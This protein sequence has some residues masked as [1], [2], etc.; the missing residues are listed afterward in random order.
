MK[1]NRQILIL[2]FLLTCFTNLLA[3][4]YL[5]DAQNIT[6]QHG[7]S[8][9]MTSAVFH[10]QQGFLW[11]GTK[12]GLNRYDGYTFQQYTAEKNGLSY[13]Q[14]IRKIQIDTAGNL[15]L[16]YSYV[17]NGEFVTTVDIFNP[18]TQKAVPFDQYFNH[19]TPFSTTEF[20]YLNIDD[21][22]N[23]IWLT[24]KKGAIF[25]YQNGIFRKVFEK[26][27]ANFKYLSIDSGGDIW[28]GTKQQL[29]RIS[30]SGKLL[31]TVQL[32]HSISG[33][34]SGEQDKIWLTTTDFS[35]LPRQT[36]FWCKEKN[37][38]NLKE[39]VL[40]QEGHGSSHPQQ[41]FRSK[42]GFWYVIIDY[43]FHL[44][45][46]KGEWL[47]DFNSLLDYEA[48]TNFTDCLEMG[49]NV[50]FSSPA[51]LIQTTIKTNPFQLVH[52][53]EVLSDCRDITE[54]DKGNIYFLNAN[55]Y[56]WNKSNNQLKKLS[57]TPNNIGLVYTDSTLFSGVYSGNILGNKLDL[58]TNQETIIPSAGYNQLKTLIATNTKHLYLIGQTKGLAYL[59]LEQNK[60]LPFEHYNEFKQLK[61]ANISYFHRNDTGIWI[62]TDLGIFLMDEK[63]GIL[64]H[65][66]QAS[67]DLPF[68]PIRYIYEDKAG[69]F[70][71]A[72]KGGGIIRWAPYS[73][74]SKALQLTTMDGLSNN[75]TYAIHE[76]DFD[77]L[78]ISSD[79]GLMSM[80]KK[81]YQVKIY[82]TDDGLPHNEFNQTADYKAKDGALYFGGLGGLITFHPKDLYNNTENNSPLEFTKLYLLEDN[83]EKSTDKTQLL[84]TSDE[85]SIK[86]EDKFFEVHF[87]LLDFDRSEEHQYAYQVQGYSDHWNYSKE[88]Y[89]RIT[90]LPYGTYQLKV[91]GKN[92]KTGWSKQ[93]LTLTIKVLKP[94]YLEW[95]FGLLLFLF[96]LS[97]SILI[98]QW[99]EQKIIK[100]NQRLEEEVQ[101]RTKTIQNQAKKLKDLDKAK[102]RFFSNITH[103]F[104]TPL[105][106]VIGPLEQLIAQSSSSDLRQKL[107]RILKNAQH[108]L[109]LINQLLDLSK[110]EGGK[111]AI[112]VSRGDIIAYT[113]ELTKRF[114][115][116]AEE[117][118]QRLN[119]ISQ[120]TT[121]ETS[122]DKRKWD[123]II[124]NLLSNAIK[125]TPPDKAI[126]LSLMAIQKGEK[127]FIRLD[128]K[129]TGS[130]IEKDHLKQIFDRFYQ[131]DYS[132]TR[133]QSGTG[134]GLALVKELVE[135]QG[136]EITVS[137][138]LYKGTSFEVHLPVLESEATVSWEDSPA[139]SP[140]ALSTNLTAI[141]KEENV[142]VSQENVL[143]KKEK[144][145]LLI[146][147]DNTEMRA[148]IRSC[149]DPNLYAITEAADGEEGIK[150][151]LDLVPDLIISDVMMPKKDGFE[152][153][154]TIRKT[155]S[156]SHIPF[157]LLTA[158]ASLSSRLKG[159]Q[160]G[161][162]AYLTKPFSPKELTLRIQ[163]LIEYR[164]LLQQY[165]QHHFPLV[166]KMEKQ[167]PKEDAF[168]VELR[169]YI[170]EHLDESNLSGDR[171]GK[172]F[173][174]S[175]VH[176]HRKLKALT[177]Q[178][179]SEF[180]RAIRLKKAF[181]LLQEG[182]FNI[183][184]IAYQTGF[185][186]IS[187]FSRS[188]K[189]A[190]GK[191]PSKL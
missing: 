169:N 138:E 117:K 181:E 74:D 115:P 13:N 126:Q 135:L 129:D 67:G 47:F 87:A 183:S 75:Y 163:K 23:R 166:T 120:I 11:I 92:N 77:N 53:R 114:Q 76:D 170:L 151:A 44:F 35:I 176:L 106:L 95:W 124:Y 161:A 110:I 4:T 38:P 131:V 27:G 57:K 174:I 69:I 111:M 21:P 162:D 70:W 145:E 119:F 17:S 142:L 153:V 62:A 143:P 184:E 99:R 123:K 154:Q 102:T 31:E 175:R 150:K 39:L 86:P 58:K 167:T 10:D 93:E 20:S 100:D 96:A 122:F 165:Y 104:R 45:N 7:L 109:I 101:D 85:I 155:I 157:I 15:W 168:I 108:L 52:K 19:N 84:Y 182:E 78:W 66:D 6:S 50:W 51:G 56:Q 191:A 171:I 187:H 186:S 63:K 33:L 32:P 152:V 82:T 37:N 55:L 133:Q 156:T 160:Q 68:N 130:G 116:L 164:H 30:F 81:D 88:N 158:K 48:K 42:K 140:V 26:K 46:D 5:F 121:W 40:K 2:L 64:Q 41:A 189:K 147:E 8:N 43:H 177:N 159:L 103:E 14:N 172:H 9:L 118:N 146:I 60:Y 127:E 112:A 132:S 134:I 180:V 179:I 22:K 144:L 65:F 25:L 59:H 148:Y 128:V 105:T 71:L 149:I 12:Y 24:N 97:I 125:F 139:L 1:I 80:N 72:T 36:Y 136:G 107:D 54:D 185:S 94:F 34:W 28:L 98:L 188:F 90:N 173:A 141:P 91:K 29:Y 3:Q 16:F 190:Y 113:Q 178:P 83:K 89:I 79:K 137:S 49:N 61:D 18:I 73:K